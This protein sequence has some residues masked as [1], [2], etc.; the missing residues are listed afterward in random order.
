MEKFEKFK[1]LFEDLRED[2]LLAMFAPVLLMVRRLTMLYLAM[3][4][5]GHQWL[6][7]LAFLTLNLVSACFVI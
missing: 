4:V 6:Q 5:T 1:P 7:V 3:F 2:S